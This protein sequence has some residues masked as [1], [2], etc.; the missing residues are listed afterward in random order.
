M[1][2]LEK[3]NKLI[4][5]QE[6]IKLLAVYFDVQ[7]KKDKIF[8][9]TLCKKFESIKITQNYRKYISKEK[10]VEAKHYLRAQ[11]NF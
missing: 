5:L 10:N 3:S 6:S 8:M 1:Y 2:D 9:K 11:I 7:L 4:D